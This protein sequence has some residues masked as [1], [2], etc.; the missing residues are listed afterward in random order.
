MQL[1][2]KRQLYQL[3][4]S[5]SVSPATDMFVCTRVR[6]HGVDEGQRPG[7]VQ[8][9]KGLGTGRERLLPARN[10]AATP[11][12]TGLAVYLRAVFRTLI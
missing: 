1:L 10:E 2:G 9:S 11:H 6:V 12:S 7:G 4:Q 5:H 8:R 3:R